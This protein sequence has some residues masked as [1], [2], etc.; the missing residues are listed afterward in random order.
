MTSPAPAPRN[1]ASALPTAPSV[2]AIAV[3]IFDS[4]TSRKIEA[5]TTKPGSLGMG[6]L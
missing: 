5:A 4:I 3:C 1:T 6:L 2:L